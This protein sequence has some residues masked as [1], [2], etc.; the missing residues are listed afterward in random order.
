[1]VDWLVLLSD[2]DMKHY[3]I[4]KAVVVLGSNNVGFDVSIVWRGAGDASLLMGDA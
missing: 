1:M 3:L 2:F 4:A